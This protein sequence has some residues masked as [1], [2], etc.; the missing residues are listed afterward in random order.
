MLNTLFI[1]EFIDIMEQ[2]FYYQ[3]YN[4]QCNS[5]AQTKDLYS[6]D[7]LNEGTILKSCNLLIAT[8]SVSRNRSRNV[9]VVIDIIEMSV[10]YY[11]VELIYKT[12]LNSI[13]DM[14][15]NQIQAVINIINK[16]I[17]LA[18]FQTRPV[19]KLRNIIF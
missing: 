5:V 15:L 3:N 10:K 11:I 9:E 19:L 6:C 16:N 2:Y 14:V 17:V 13:Y 18:F 4:W 12:N 8:F 1:D 7:S